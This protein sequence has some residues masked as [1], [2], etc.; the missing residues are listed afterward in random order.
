MNMPAIEILRLIE[1]LQDSNGV[2]L[3]GETDGDGYWVGT[4]L[5]IAGVPVLVGE[6][7]IEEVIET[8]AATPIP[9]TKPWVLGVAA[10]KGAL[11]PIYCGDMLFRGQPYTG[12]VRDYCMVIRRPG[13]YFGITLSGVKRDLR[14]PAAERDMDHPVD[15]DFARFTEGGFHYG[16][17]FFAVLDLDKLVADENLANA[18]ATRRT[19]TRRHGNDQ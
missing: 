4:A 7:E 11:L 1:R 8:P 2:S 15:P 17:E 13:M 16:D 5:A 9:G 18:S 3:P 10:Y 12:R 14:L 6:G 19:A